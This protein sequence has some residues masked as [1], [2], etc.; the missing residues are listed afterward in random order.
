[1]ESSADNTCGVCSLVFDTEESLN[2][3]K[4][5][6]FEQAR[7]S[8]NNRTIKN[9]MDM[10]TDDVGTDHMVA[11]DGDTDT[12]D[13]INKDTEK[14]KEKKHGEDEIGQ[15]EDKYYSGDDTVEEKNN[16][17]SKRCFNT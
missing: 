4:R 12:K 10:D 6:H 13:E 15:L 1:M 5:I 14:H 11:D 3:H 2:K 7:N 8:H 17:Y 9:N 16:T